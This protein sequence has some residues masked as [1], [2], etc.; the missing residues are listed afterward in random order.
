MPG[1]KQR[2]LPHSPGGLC[3]KTRDKYDHEGA[4][5]R[6]QREAGQARCFA[7]LFV[8]ITLNLVFLVRI[9]GAGV[10]PNY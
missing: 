4:M 3:L 2:P 5:T 8:D 1:E 6:R 7:A 10:V 9:S